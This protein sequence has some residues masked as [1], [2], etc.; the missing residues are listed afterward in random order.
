MRTVSVVLLA[1]SYFAG[2]FFLTSLI[3]KR[4]PEELLYS[5][6]GVVPGL[7]FF[8]LFAGVFLAAR[9]LYRRYMQRL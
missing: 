9:A 4:W 2:I 1:I 6:D 3:V 8:S 5:N 7:I